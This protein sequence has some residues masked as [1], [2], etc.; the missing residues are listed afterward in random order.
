L[1]WEWCKDGGMVGDGVSH[2]RRARARSV[3][4][5]SLMFLFS[6]FRKYFCARVK[7]VSISSLIFLFLF[8]FL[9]FVK[10]S[11]QGLNQFF[12]PLLPLFFLFSSSFLLLFFFF[13][14]FLFFLFFLFL[15][16]LFFL[17]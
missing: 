12:S 6:S 10:I 15:F 13:F 11:V 8:S 9:C 2:V 17:F 14:L 16:F 5:S 4:I 1:C 3:S 7:S